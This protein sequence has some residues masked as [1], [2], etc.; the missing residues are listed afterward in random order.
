MAI[1]CNDIR[2]LVIF[3]RSI[4]SQSSALKLLAEL[5]SDNNL[6]DRDCSWFYILG[7]LVKKF[8]RIDYSAYYQTIMHQVIKAFTIIINGD[9]EDSL[10]K[11]TTSDNYLQIQPVLKSVAMTLAYLIL[12]ASQPQH[13]FIKSCI[14]RVFVLIISSLDYVNPPEYLNDL[15]T[16]S[17]AFVRSYLIRFR[18]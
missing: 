17:K 7:E 5:F 15:I 11:L 12:P 9:N 3:L 2:Y 13:Y 14:Q 10:K 4:K 1:D 8:P 16:F 6:W 18:G